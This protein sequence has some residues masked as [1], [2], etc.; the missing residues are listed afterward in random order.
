MMSALHFIIKPINHPI[1]F[2]KGTADPSL[3]CRHRIRRIGFEEIAIEKPA[4]YRPFVIG[5][6]PQAMN[7]GGRSLCLILGFESVASCHPMAVA[8]TLLTSIR[9][10]VAIVFYRCAIPIASVF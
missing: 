3:P 10:V 1:W 9:Q 8:W 2:A 4:G 6:D 5:I 7:T